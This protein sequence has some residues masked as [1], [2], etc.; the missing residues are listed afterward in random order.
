MCREGKVQEAYELAKAD[1]SAMSSYPWVQREMGWALYYMIKN[2][3]DVGNLGKLLEHLDELKSLNLLTIE[4]DSM[5]FNNVQFKIAEFIK[6]HVFLNDTD[7]HSK[8]SIIFSK[9]KDYSFQSSKGHSFMLQSYIKFEAWPEM[10][11]FI[12]WWNFD[13]LTPDDFIPY[14]NHNGKK[15]LA[16]AERAYIAYSKALLKLH[17]PE[18]IELFLPKLDAL[19]NNHKEMIY[20]GYYYGKLLLSLGSNVNEALSV[21]IPFARRK[22]SEFWVWQLLSEV[23]IYDE[24][25][26]LACLLRAVNCHTQESF[27]GKVRIK[28]ADLYIKQMHFDLA[29]YQ[30]DTVANCYVSHG[31]HLPNEIDNWMHQPWYSTTVSNGRDTIDYK[32]IT[33]E[34]LCDGAEESLAVVTYVDKTSNKSSMI[35]GCKLRICQKLHFKV[36]VGNVLKL[37]YITESDGRVKVL[38]AVRTQ[39]IINLNYA[40]IVEGAINKRDDR[41][42]AFLNLKSINCF[43][44]P[45]IVMKYHLKNGDNVK[46]LIVYDYNRKK[47]KWNW[48]CVNVISKRR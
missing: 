3:V 10:A 44:A 32:S 17:D 5:I 37:H 22:M 15:M 27:L 1:M 16:L 12:D 40:K 29:R 23:F 34:I 38:S 7:L 45:T 33:D 28:L 31:W 21:I 35:Y 39:L 2:D 14:V 47:N 41:D 19:S 42:F 36:S 25:K 48:V 46:G 13:N 9:L 26:K 4:S 11:D 18:R 20:L 30:I 43:I 24:E 8:L 6:N